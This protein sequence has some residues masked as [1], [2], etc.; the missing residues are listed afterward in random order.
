MTDTQT[1][2]LI[3]GLVAVSL[4]VIGIG[5]SRRRNSSRLKAFEQRLRNITFHDQAKADRLIAFERD[6]LKRKG[7]PEEPLE[8]LMER[9]IQRWERDNASAAPLY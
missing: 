9:A 3:V 5:V 8:A 2:A 1:L 4:A 7:R 6:E